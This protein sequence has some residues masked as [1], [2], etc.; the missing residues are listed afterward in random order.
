MKMDNFFADMMCSAEAE[1]QKVLEANKKACNLSVTNNVISVLFE[2]SRP[3]VM[4]I[5][6]RL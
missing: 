4:C 3:F 2:N 1:L 5:G 6:I